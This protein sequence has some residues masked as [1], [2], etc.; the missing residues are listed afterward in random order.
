MAEWHNVR[1]EIV[2]NQDTESTQMPPWQSPSRLVRL[3][4]HMSV[5]FCVFRNAPIFGANFMSQTIS[6]VLLYNAI[7][8]GIKLVIL[9][10][11]GL[12]VDLLIGGA[13]LCHDGVTTHRPVLP[14]HIEAALTKIKLLPQNNP[15]ARSTSNI[16]AYSSL[17]LGIA[18]GPTKPATNAVSKSIDCVHHNWQMLD[19]RLITP[20]TQLWKI[21]L[22]T[23]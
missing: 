19:P 13:S 4:K 17:S 3:K 11:T 15:P 5:C 7:S 23:M 21:G 1:Y 22:L 6:I 14:P 8:C 20:S 2:Q 12:C 9:Q 18:M 10:G 16:G